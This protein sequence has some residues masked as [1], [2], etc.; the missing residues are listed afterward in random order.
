MKRGRKGG[1]G[2]LPLA[3]VTRP[4]TLLH[5]LNNYFVLNKHQKMNLR[6]QNQERER[7]EE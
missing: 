7:G 5:L 4:T 2:G 6:Y 3:L 1:K